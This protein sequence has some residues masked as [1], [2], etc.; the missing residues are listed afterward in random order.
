MC[1]IMQEVSGLWGSRRVGERCQRPSDRQRAGPVGF[2]EK[3]A[4]GRRVAGRPTGIRL[5]AG[6]WRGERAQP[7]TTAA[8]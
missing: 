8:P 4:V 5:G 6:K 2:A 3:S 1:D 7:V